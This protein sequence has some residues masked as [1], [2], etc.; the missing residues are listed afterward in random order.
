MV[1]CPTDT[2]DRPRVSFGLE[3]TTMNPFESFVLAL[4]DLISGFLDGLVALLQ[5]LGIG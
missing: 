5:S 4:Q 2:G 3:D 1:G